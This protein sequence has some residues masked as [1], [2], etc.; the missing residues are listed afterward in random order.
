[1]P[2]TIASAAARSSGQEA[3]LGS[4]RREK[5]NYCYATSLAWESPRGTSCRRGPSFRHCSLSAQ[6]VH[7]QAVL[8]LFACLFRSCSFILCPHLHFGKRH[9]SQVYASS[10]A[11]T[12]TTRS[13]RNT[14]FLA[15]AISFLRLYSTY[16]YK[17]LTLIQTLI[18][19][20]RHRGSPHTPNASPPS[21]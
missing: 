1:M 18:R 7:I 21:S 3:S 10:S 6:G 19:T 12:A 17:G 8:S 5:K 20:L 15:I 14:Q 11:L 16:S 4:A 9:A 2:T 13:H